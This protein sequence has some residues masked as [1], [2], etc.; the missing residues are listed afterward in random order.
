MCFIFSF[1]NIIIIIF[2]K[3]FF[4]IS[5]HNSQYNGGF[6]PASAGFPAVGQ[7]IDY[8]SMGHGNYMNA[9]AFPSDCSHGMGRIGTRNQFHHYARP[10]NSQQSETC[11][12]SSN[13]HD[14]TAL[15][16]RP[17][18]STTYNN[19]IDTNNSFSYGGQSKYQPKKTNTKKKRTKQTYDDEDDTLEDLCTN[20]KIDYDKVY[21]GFS[22][23]DSKFT[24]A[25]STT[26][27]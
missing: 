16:L 7:S 5:D 24:P 4:I 11:P 26:N 1:Y 13:A 27:K 6:S 22:Q 18:S 3:T 2:V 12:S 19:N 25:F 23:K 20:G 9:I 14:S 21:F 10:M 15:D 17:R 8:R